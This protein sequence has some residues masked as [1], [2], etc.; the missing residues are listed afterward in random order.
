MAR[1]SRGRRPPGS[2]FLALPRYSSPHSACVEPCRPQRTPESGAMSHRT[3]AACTAAALLAA[4]PLGA[5]SSVSFDVGTYGSFTRFDR[6]LFL[7]DGLGFGARL[8]MGFEAAGHSLRFETEL[9]RS[10]SERAG[11]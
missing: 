3:V 5:Q 4:A 1:P 10:G 8:G 2:S 11:A 6:S 7:D 9:A